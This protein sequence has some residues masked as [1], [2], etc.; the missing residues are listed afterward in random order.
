MQENST[1]TANDVLSLA[2]HWV[3]TEIFQYRQ[4]GQT[5]GAYRQVCAARGSEAHQCA[6]QMLTSVL[7]WDYDRAVDWLI[8]TKDEYLAVK[9]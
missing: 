8:A 6:F 2:R 9:S 3:Q 4:A 1:P 5:T 7:D